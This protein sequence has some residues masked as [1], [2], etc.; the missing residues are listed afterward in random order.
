MLTDSFTRTGKPSANM[1]RH[2]MCLLLSAICDYF[3]CILACCR[4]IST[5]KANSAFH[6][7]GVGKGVPASAGKTTAGMVH[8]VSRWTWGVQV[9]QWDPLRTRAIPERLR[10]VI[11]T[12]RYTNPR[13]PYITLPCLKPLSDVSFPYIFS[14]ITKVWSTF[15]AA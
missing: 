7:S 15:V 14:F 4:S 13:L 12:R 6:P 9:K 3:I 8:S 11:M 5:V 1:L 2:I 10:G